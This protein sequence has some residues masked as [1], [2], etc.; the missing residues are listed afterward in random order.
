MPSIGGGLVVSIS[1]R[2]IVDSQMPMT[3]MGTLM[4]K[5]QCHEK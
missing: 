2:K 3:P 4:R 5:I 1:G